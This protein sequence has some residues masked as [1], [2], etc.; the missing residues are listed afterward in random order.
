MIEPRRRAGPRR[1]G[2][3]AVKRRSHCRDVE[4]PVADRDADP[5][6][7]PGTRAKRAEWQVLDGEVA[8]R[9]VGAFDKTA[10]GGI[11]GLVEGGW[12]VLTPASLL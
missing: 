7:Q 9:R 8:A 10:P 4:D 5:R 6:R 2:G 3:E 1:V 11:V 12:H